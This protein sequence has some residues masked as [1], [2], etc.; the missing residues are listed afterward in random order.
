MKLEFNSTVPAIS[1]PL[2]RLYTALKSRPREIPRRAGQ[3]ARLRNDLTRSLRQC[4]PS[5]LTN[6][7]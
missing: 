4:P 1:P 7:S 6:F 5:S 2:L 3:N